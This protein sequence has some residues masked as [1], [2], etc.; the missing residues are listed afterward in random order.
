MPTT[1]PAARTVF[2]CLD[3]TAAELAAV[4]EE[5]TPPPTYT[6]RRSACYSFCT[7]SVPEADA[8]RVLAA[9]TAAGVDAEAV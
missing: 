2:E 9:L 8:P 5:L 3:A 6:A 4:C 1:A 7:L